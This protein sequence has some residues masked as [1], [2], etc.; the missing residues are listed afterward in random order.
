M[1]TRQRNKAFKRLGI[2]FS[3]LILALVII[4]LYDSGLPKAI[5]AVGVTIS[6]TFALIFYIQ[7]NIALAEAK[8]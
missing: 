8:G 7:G 1:I 5:T 4:G 2:S 6:I 3:L